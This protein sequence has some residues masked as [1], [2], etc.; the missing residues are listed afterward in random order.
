MAFTRFHYYRRHIP[1]C[2]TWV[3]VAEDEDTGVF[4]FPIRPICKAMQVDS[5]SQIEVIKHNWKLA[6]AH[7]VIPI[8]TEQRQ[9]GTWMRAQQT[10][11]LPKREFGWWLA[12]VEPGK[13]ASQ[14]VR[15]KLLIRQRA[16]S[17][18][19]ESL[20]DKNDA[21]VVQTRRPLVTRDTRATADGEVLMRC[22]ACGTPLCLV[23]AG[24][25]VVPGVE[26]E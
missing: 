24:A 13:S 6:T 23:I 5:P 2:D 21:E 17:D 7:H 12:I 9:D 18:F 11:C 10:Q 22:P 16:I 15:D 3:I 14:E 4:W 25:H 1:V 8:P 20:V 19:A 26:V